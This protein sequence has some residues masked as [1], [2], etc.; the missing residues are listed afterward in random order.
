[1]EIK[2]FRFGARW[3]I[4]DITR[5]YKTFTVK[6]YSKTVR[7]A[8]NCFCNLKM[9]EVKKV[10]IFFNRTQQLSSDLGFTLWQLLPAHPGLACLLDAGQGAFVLEPALMEDSWPPSVTGHHLSPENILP[11]FSGQSQREDTL[12]KWEFNSKEGTLPFLSILVLG[13]LISYLQ[14]A[15]LS[16]LE[17]EF[18]LPITH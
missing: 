11:F 18:I 1:M 16:L 13:N 9:M 5:E 10:L 6:S 8:K 4:C 2:P 15:P 12:L 14:E 3:V 17:V 7:S